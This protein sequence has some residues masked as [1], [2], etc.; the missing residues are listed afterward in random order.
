[1][2]WVSRWDF[3]APGDVDRI[4]DDA[5]SIGV[6]DVLWQARGVFDAY[7]ESSIEPWGEALDDPDGSGLGPGFDPLALA[8]SGARERG[9]RLHAWVN[10]FSL[11]RGEA[12]PRSPTHAL[13]SEA[14]WRVVDQ[15]GKPQPP[16][17]GYVWANVA[18]DPVHDR[19]VDVL[20]DIVDRYRVDGV[21][22]D[23]MHA[24]PVDLGGRIYPADTGTLE[25]FAR[26]T[27]RSALESDR[28]LEAF[29]GW[30][31]DR[32][33]R[34]ARRVRAAV[35]PRGSGVELSVTSAPRPELARES[36]LQD[37]ARWLES[38]VVD[39]VYARGRAMD[40]EAL[41]A[42]ALLAP[43]GRVTP[44]LSLGGIANE[45]ALLSRLRAFEDGRGVGLFAYAAIFDS[46]DP[47]QPQ[48]PAALTD[49]LVR[50]Q[51]LRLWHEER[52]TRVSP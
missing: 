51:A 8:V 47:A 27:G 9:L 16:G 44:G 43:G 48:T 4:L 52:R 24:G 7:Y 46:A 18:I 36:A 6:T 15:S 14:S 31:R 34:L 3:Q 26:A 30:L 35:A 10:V 25:L 1:A 45:D 12:P 17:R 29:R 32:V 38:G 20:A 13:R 37:A 11:W 40:A 42:W 23:Q 33:T 28:D 49:R 5:A 50:R 21:H 22:L 41:D 39:R 2:M 19:V